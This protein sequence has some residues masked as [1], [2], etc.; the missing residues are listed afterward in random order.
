[1][2][3]GG[4]SAAGLGQYV[5]ATGNS[6]QQQQLLQT[7]QN[8]LA[9]GDL[10][11]ANSAFQSLQQVVQNSATA[12]GSTLTSNSQVSNDLATLGSAISA[13]DLTGAQSAFATIQSDL[14][15]NATPSQT[16]ESSAASQ[17]VQLVAELLSTVSPSSNSSSSSGSDLTT[18]V[19][20]QVYGSRS[21]LN[22]QG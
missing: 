7:L 9:S 8:S 4:I 16:N 14:K 19:L 21:G 20:Q 17:S 18:S 2:A 5:L 22:V 6:N 11:V 1:M 10:S 3:I 15:A 13:G 12:S